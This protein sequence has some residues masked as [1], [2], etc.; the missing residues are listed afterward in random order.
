MTPEQSEKIAAAVQA[1]LRE[2]QQAM[3]SNPTGEF[4]DAILHA[5]L[6]TMLFVKYTLAAEF[7]TPPEGNGELK[8]D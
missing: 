7:A 6:T 8:D 2:I 4:K 1:E 3:I 5:I